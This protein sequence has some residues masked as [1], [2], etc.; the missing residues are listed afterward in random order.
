MQ[1]NQCDCSS[2]STRHKKG[3]GDK[4]SKGGKGGE[5]D[6]EASAAMEARAAREARA[7]KMLRGRGGCVPPGQVDEVANELARLPVPQLGCAIVRATV[8]KIGDHKRSGA[9]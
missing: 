4:G 5:G 7:A 6:K 2:T 8:H 9:D 1:S 3:K